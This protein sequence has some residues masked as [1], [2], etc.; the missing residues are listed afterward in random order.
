M[1]TLAGERVEEPG[2]VADEQPAGTGA[3]GHAVTERPGA[4][5]GVQRLAVAPQRRVLVGR[6]DGG[7]DGGGHRAGA[8]TGQRRAPRRAQHDPDVH[9]AAGDRRDAD[10]A[11]AQDPHPRVA[12]AG[13]VRCPRGG[14]SARSAVR[15]GRDDRR[16]PRARRPNADRRHRR[17]SPARRWRTA[18]SGSRTSSRRAAMST[19]ATRQ[20]S[21]TSAPARPGEVEQRRVEARAVEADGRTTAGLG[22][23]GQPERGP[24]AG[25]DAHR[26]DGP[27]DGGDRRRDPGRRAPARPRRPATRRPRRR[28][29]PRSRTARGR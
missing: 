11:V 13:R 8:V 9:P 2:G 6:R 3:P 28:A 15:A 10:V 18:P 29:R 26:R 17:R 14:R 4:R 7:D 24:A 25:L 22:A 1:E 20:P 27:R 12:D 19:S 21:R 23:V 16:R 5:D